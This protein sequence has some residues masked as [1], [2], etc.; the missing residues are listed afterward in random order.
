MA[1]VNKIQKTWN[2][3]FIY[4][5]LGTDKLKE[6]LYESLYTSRYLPIEDRKNKTF[7]DLLTRLYG[8]N[9]VTELS[10]ICTKDVLQSKLERDQANEIRLRDIKIDQLN[11]LNRDLQA[12]ID[13][14]KARS[15]SPTEHSV[16]RPTKPQWRPVPSSVPI[17]PR[18]KT[19][20]RQ[21]LKPISVQ[22][23][24]KPGAN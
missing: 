17:K 21:T 24:T 2:F 11:R 4:F 12:E 6:E 13:R 14:L 7:Y 20:A 19:K 15:T 18:E 16:I 5:L 10:R 8:I 3:L 23:D 9:Q 22:F 1:L